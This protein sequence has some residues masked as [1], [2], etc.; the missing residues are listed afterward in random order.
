MVI[1]ADELPVQIEGDRPSD[2]AVRMAASAAAPLIEAGGTIRVVTTEGG[3]IR[4][5]WSETMTDLAQI[6]DQ[7]IGTA[8][9]WIEDI[10]VGERVLAFVHSSN[11][12][13][14]SSLTAMARSDSEIA[15]VVFE[16]FMPGDNAGHAVNTL[17]SVGINAISCRLGEFSQAIMQMERGAAAAG[18]PV[19]TPVLEPVDTKR[20]AA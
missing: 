1:D 8:S 11:S 10:N 7:K 16:G 2:Y 15:A 13:L 20:V 19:V 18:T 5:S 9:R 12:E 3:Q 14:L 6:E 4:T 17:T